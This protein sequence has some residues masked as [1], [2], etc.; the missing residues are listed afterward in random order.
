MKAK[1]STRY[2]NT[3]KDYFLAKLPGYVWRCLVAR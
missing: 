2:K 1:C 3:D